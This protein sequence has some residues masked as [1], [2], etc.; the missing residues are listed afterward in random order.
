MERNNAGKSTKATGQRPAGR[1]AINGNETGVPFTADNQP[2]ADAKRE[3][4]RKKRFGKEL[5]RALFEQDFSGDA[6]SKKACAKY[7]GLPEE[8]VT[9]EIMF[10]FRPVCTLG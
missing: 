1:G 8:D 3:R 7:F 5:A 9:F 10:L 6:R 2:P 4:W